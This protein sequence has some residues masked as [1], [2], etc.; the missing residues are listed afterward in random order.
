MF[1]D[2]LVNANATRWNFPFLYDQVFGDYRHHGLFDWIL[3][4][5]LINRLFAVHN[6]SALSLP[7]GFVQPPGDH[8]H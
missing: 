4:Y 2:A 5:G 3:G 7:G 8:I 1:L 6:T